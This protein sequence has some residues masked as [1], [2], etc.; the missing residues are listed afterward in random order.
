[1]MDEL[2]PVILPYL[3]KIWRRKKGELVNDL[4]TGHNIVLGPPIPGIMWIIGVKTWSEV[5][6]HNLHSSKQVDPCEIKL[7][8]QAATKS[9]VWDKTPAS[10]SQSIKI[11]N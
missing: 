7:W 5:P 6:G 2:D 3:T 8:A 1:M 11:K 4:F 10:E 9:E